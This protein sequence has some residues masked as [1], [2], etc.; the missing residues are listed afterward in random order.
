M[1][2]NGL[3]NLSIKQSSVRSVVVV[4]A[5][6]AGVQIFI[7]PFAKPRRLD[8]LQRTNFLLQLACTRD[9]TVCGK[10]RMER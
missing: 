5:L 6:L 1:I 4:D 7:E 3:W 9:I 10:T 2:R 8:G